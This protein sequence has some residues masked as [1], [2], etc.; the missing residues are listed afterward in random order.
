MGWA[1]AT[2]LFRT[3]IESAK[4]VIPDQNARTEF[5]APIYKVTTP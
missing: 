3:I 4:K 5:Y 1:S 2:P